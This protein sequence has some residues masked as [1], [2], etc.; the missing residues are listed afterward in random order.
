MKRSNGGFTVV[1][2]CLLNGIKMQVGNE[3]MKFRHKM[4]IIALLSFDF[5]GGAFKVGMRFLKNAAGLGTDTIRLA[6]QELVDAKF[7][8]V[9][10]VKNCVNEYDL[11]PFYEKFLES[12][13][14]LT[15]AT[16]T[17][18]SYVDYEIPEDLR[19]ALQLDNQE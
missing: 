6:I 2:N 12:Q 13:L 8:R 9:S 1:P 14:S 4:V 18:T 7:L 5:H 15:P 17:P 3:E 16:P 19:R 10:R 11:T